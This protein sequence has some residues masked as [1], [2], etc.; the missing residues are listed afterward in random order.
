M[1]NFVVSVRGGISSASALKLILDQHP[2]A[3]VKA[4]FADVKGTGYSHFWSDMPE[5]EYLLHERFG[6]ESRDTYR[7]IWQVASYLQHPIHRIEDGRSI[8]AVFGETKSFSFLAGN[9]VVCKASEYLK[10]E[11]I[12]QWVEDTYPPSSEITMVFGFVK[13][14]D[15]R[16]V[17]AQGY[18]SWRLPQY[19]IKC[20]APL[21]ESFDQDKVLID[22]CHLG[23]WLFQIG[24]EPPA[25]YVDGLPHNNCQGRCVHAGQTQWEVVYNTDFE[26]YMYA[27]WQEMRIRKLVGVKS[28]IL[29]NQRKGADPKLTLYDFIEMIKSGDI[30][31]RDLGSACG[32]FTSPAFARFN[33]GILTKNA[34]EEVNSSF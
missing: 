20:V 13:F 22:S 21:I 14:E 4:V 10:R 11:A 26:G 28:T 16:L 24:I 9:K 1:K 23:D 25:A 6:G 34:E 17:N 12:A 5:I 27:A 29:K 7:F 19:H 33:K 3:D 30:N 31:R 8:Y 18:W 15:H 2:S 32:C